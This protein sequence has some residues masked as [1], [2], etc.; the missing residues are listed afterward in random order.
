MKRYCLAVLPAAFLSVCALCWTS[1]TAGGKHSSA[2]TRVWAGWSLHAQALFANASCSLASFSFFQCGA[3]PPPP[4]CPPDDGGGPICF[5]DCGGCTSP[6]IL[7]LNG[8]GF[9]L[10]D[11]SHGVL[12]DI[13]GTGYPVQIAWTAAGADNAFLCLPDPD[14]KCD[15]GKDLFGN[16]TPQPTSPNPNGFLALAIYDQPANG[17]NS[18]GV[19][20]AHDKIFSSLRLWIDA[21][22][23]GV[24]QP[25]ELFTLPEMGVDSIS[26]KYHASMRR[27]QF[28]NL[29]R[30][31]SRVNPDG[32]PDNSDVGRT[33]Y[34][35]F[36]TTK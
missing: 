28:G 22:H 1:S 14:G 35:V 4:D 17:G 30:Y 34:D 20:D 11:A 16:F 6:V 31:R 21:N 12:F 25:S 29:F 26:L 5:R 18:D 8:D 2:L 32:Q 36:L 27:D 24:S 23:D 15:D 33:A 19:I 10:T 7:D 3:P 9:S 13:A